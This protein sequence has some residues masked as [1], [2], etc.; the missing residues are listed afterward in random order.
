MDEACDRFEEARLT[1]PQPHLK[2]YLDDLPVPA[3]PALFGEH[4]WRVIR[5]LWNQE[6]GL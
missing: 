6:A 1:G 5:V 4:T 3:R 2:G